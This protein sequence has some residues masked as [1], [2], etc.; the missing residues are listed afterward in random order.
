ML[1]GIYSGFIA[2][3]F[4]LLLFQILSAQPSLT[5]EIN[6]PI[7]QEISGK[8]KFQYQVKLAE[9]QYAKIM[10]K[11]VGVDA[12]LKLY[13]SKNEPVY[14]VD[15]NYTSTGSELLEAV[16]D[17]PETYVVEVSKADFSSTGKFQIELVETRTANNKDLALDKARRLLFQANGFWQ[18]DEYDEALKAAE[19]AL[20]IAKP[21]IDLNDSFMATI[22]YMVAN[23][24]S[25][26]GEY[27]KA[28]KL[29]KQS[30]A[31]NENAHGK[32]N[33][34]SSVIV[35]ELGNLYNQKA[36]YI[37]AEKQ[38]LHALEIRKKFLKPNHL[39]ISQT[40]NDLGTLS[41][42][43]GDNAKAEFYLKRCL[44]IRENA[45][46]SD[47]PRIA[48]TLSNIA[49]LYDDLKKS[50]PLYLRSL[51]IREKAFGKESVDVAKIV[52]NMATLYIAN[53]DYEKAES[54]GTRSL[55]NLEKNLGPEHPFVTLRLNLLGIV[56]V[57][58]EK[59]IDAQNAY[60]RAIAIREK[61]QGLFHPELAG[62]ISNLAIAFALQG[63][64]EKA[65]AAEKRANEIVELN[66]STNLGTGSE[67]EKIQYLKTVNLV[68]YLSLTL[69][70]E[71]S[72]KAADLAFQAV[73]QQK[74][75]VLD[76]FSNQLNTLR[77]RANESNRRLLDELGKKN[78]QLSSLLVSGTNGS[79]ISDYQAK[80]K[81][82]TDEKEWLEGE[83]SRRAST[84][85]EKSKIV[86]VNEIQSKL[87]ENSALV[88]FYAYP[89]VKFKESMNLKNRRSVQTRYAV[90]I[91]QSNGAVHSIDLGE[92]REIN[93]LIIS[94]RNSLQDSK[95][96][97]VTRTSNALFQKI[98]APIQEALD[99]TTQLLIS[100]D[101]Q[102]NL[103]PFEA[104][105][106][107][108]GKYLVEKYSI[109]YLSSGRD[110]LRIQNERPNNNP[111]LIIANPNFGESQTA[112]QNNA[113]QP[114]Q[115]KRNVNVA[116]NLRDTYFAPLSGTELEGRNIKNLLTDANFLV[117]DEA[118]K[119]AIL[120]VKSPN[121]LHIAT[122]GFFIKGNSES[123]ETDNP[124]LRSGLAFAGANQHQGNNGILTA[125][126]GSGLNLFGT[127]L[128][129]LSACGTGLGEVQTG[130]GVFGLRRSFVLAG[131][132]SLVISLWSVS[133]YITRE[134]MTNYYKNL[135]AGFGRAESLRRAQL[136]FI[137]NPRRNHPFYWASFIESGD[138]RKINF[139]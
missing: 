132:D 27:D 32:D 57:N 86:E 139:R 129:V 102:L 77:K 66:I 127:K 39:L 109:S 19:K 130:E 14:S 9:H 60:L 95:S 42:E 104:L 54:F 23:Q 48:N 51:E 97:D 75:R 134:L 116:K 119:D 74:G 110:L 79:T 81:Q 28:E 94:F 18:N 62:T 52:Y 105:I 22:L 45:L 71:Y 30:I 91:L 128:V 31:I 35:T 90:F 15:L 124:L 4:I 11:Q 24:Y 21:Q 49:D 135:K 67:R 118:T 125:L 34:E 80:V 58:R 107:S 84:Y 113:E 138:W 123:D 98:I 73:L 101:D 40:Y 121:I 72:K 8:N 36:D 61:Y 78:E 100:P 114:L 37:N 50:E 111:A 46:A 69:N 83:I 115:A 126:E 20:E 63:N 6:K 103:I 64:I 99:S 76:I 65:I 12:R 87:P 68:F 117:G 33:L 112:K 47:D 3:L 136:Q 59:Y 131:T 43:R 38:F 88:E 89:P 82:L 53:G 17:E 96:I 1:R 16:S 120:E 13:D 56:Y 70:F 41:R 55:Y 85:F 44:E 7:S 106:D 29:F 137:K 5:L 122:H 10:L 25:Y 92:T 93:D 26:K 2:T 133:D 108:S